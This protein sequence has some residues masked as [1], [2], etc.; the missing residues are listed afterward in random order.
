MNIQGII[1]DL[2]DLTHDAMMAGGRAKE[3]KRDAERVFTRVEGDESC[4]DYKVVADGL[5]DATQALDRASE[6]F[7]MIEEMLAKI[8]EHIEMEALSAKV[9]AK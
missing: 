6:D 5:V 1:Y 7:F 4:E 9:Q 3:N 2:A 8:I